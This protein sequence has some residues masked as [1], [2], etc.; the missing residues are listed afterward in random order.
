MDIC[1]S[2]APFKK[3]N[4]NTPFNHRP[5]SLISCV[6]KVI[7]VNGDL[8]RN[9]LIENP[10]CHCG[11]AVENSEHVFFKCPS[12]QTQRITLFTETR[13]FRPLNTSL[14]LLGSDSLAPKD[15]EGIFTAVHR[16]I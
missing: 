3:G 12:Y 2:Y 4:R 5:I 13:T 10:T 15:N 6:G 11:N 14:L 8:V 9:H 7:A 1:K 16:F